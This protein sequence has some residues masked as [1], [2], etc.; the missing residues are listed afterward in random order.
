MKTFLAFCWLN[1]FLCF[2]ITN[3]IKITEM[4]SV[5]SSNYPVQIGRPFLQGE[6]ANYPQVLVNGTAV[7]TQADVKQRYADGSVK[8]A[9]LSFLI[10]VLPARS[11]VIVTFQNQSSGTNTPL[12]T[13]Q[14]QDPIYNFDAQMQL[15]APNCASCPLKTASARAMLTA[16]A[17]TYWTSGPVATTVITADQWQFDDGLTFV[18]GVETL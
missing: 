14:M 2:G 15:A 11:T 1:T 4:A 3:S 12:T 10:P 9:I 16:G 17:C 6:I 8:H 18:A 7:T 13:A 5:S